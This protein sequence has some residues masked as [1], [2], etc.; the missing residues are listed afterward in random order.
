M[1]CHRCYSTLNDVIKKKNRTISKAQGRESFC[2]RTQIARGQWRSTAPNTPKHTHTHTPEGWRPVC[3]FG[4]SPPP[5]GWTP[6]G[7]RTGCRHTRRAPG[8]GPPGCLFPFLSVT[9]SGRRCRHA[10]RHVTAVMWL[11]H[12]IMG[13]GRERERERDAFTFTFSHLADAFIQSD[14]HMCDLQCIHIVCVCVCV[15]NALL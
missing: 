8:S 1:W 10:P 13:R 3:R 15:C 2:L 9:R 7:F 6:S 5:D 14:L 11:M 12:D 4:P